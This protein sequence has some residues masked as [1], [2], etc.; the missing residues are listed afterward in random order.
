MN[1]ELTS[2][3]YPGLFKKESVT[4]IIG[5]DFGTSSSKVVIQSPTLEV[6]FAVPFKEI[7]HKSNI[8][9]LPTRPYFNKD[10][11]IMLDGLAKNIPLRELKKNLM[12]DVKLSQPFNTDIELIVDNPVIVTIGYLAKVI[13]LS[14]FWFLKEKSGAFSN[15]NIEWVLNI[16]VPSIGKSYIQKKEFFK[17]LVTVAWNLSVKSEKITLDLINNELI[18]FENNNS[19][20]YGIGSDN[21][22]AL[23]E[24][25]SETLGYAKSRLRRDDMHFL[26]DIGACTLDIS[27]FNLFKKNGQDKY[28]IFTA[29]VEW[30]GGFELHKKRIDIIKSK[31]NKWYNEL[32]VYEDPVSSIPQSLSEYLINSDNI[33]IDDIDKPFENNCREFLKKVY[34]ASKKMNPN[35]PDWH[36]GVRT[37]ISGGGRYINFYKNLL[38]IPSL[39]SIIKF[40]KPEN[41]EMEFDNDFYRIAV[42]Y[43]LSFREIDIGEIRTPEEISEIEVENIIDYTNFYVSKDQV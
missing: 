7:G 27:C 26:I 12:I 42:A 18:S 25:V 39:F 19:K 16:G 9:L 40:E 14:R 38:N 1:L 43:G 33:N 41:L 5:L 11:E 20:M 2:T 35:A 3:Q 8:Y 37:I 30:L 4:V 6:A 21:I 34:D 23:P 13:Q 31:V 32:G 17:K 29:D 24:I 28:S 10:S 15:Y 22:C 36:K